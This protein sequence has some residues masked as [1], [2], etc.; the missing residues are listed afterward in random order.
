MGVEIYS[1]KLVAILGPSRFLLWGYWFCVLAIAL[2]VAPIFARIISQLPICTS[3]D[4][5]KGTH[6]NERSKSL[7]RDLANIL[8]LSVTLI[9]APVLSFLLFN[10]DLESVA[11]K[12]N[13]KII[14]WIKAQTPDD[15]IFIAPHRG[16][17]RVDIPI[18]ARRAV[19][20][21]NGFPFREECFKEYLH[22]RTLI[23]GKKA[24]QMAQQGS[25][26]GAK[27]QKLYETRDPS[28]FVG[29]SNAYE[30]DFVIVTNKHAVSRF[31]DINLEYRDK[32]FSIYS[33]KQLRAQLDSP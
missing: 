20:Y 8:L 15:S 29:I 2:V 16:G 9:V 22:R 10:D 7:V 32:N 30:V 25:W 11:M 3:V 24:E 31:S 23:D 5:P 1:I 19:F 14:A 26:A 17:L 27:I 18:V 6:E 13:G 12:R 28:Y 33:F 21:G 4:G